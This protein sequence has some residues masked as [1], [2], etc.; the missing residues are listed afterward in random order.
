MINEL[1]NSIQ[2]IYNRKILLERYLMT[3]GGK[4]IINLEKL[5]PLL[6]ILIFDYDTEFGINYYDQN[7]IELTKGEDKETSFIVYDYIINIHTH[8]NI[9]KIEL[10]HKYLVP[11]PDDYEDSLHT[12]HNKKDHFVI[13]PEGIWKYKPNDNLINLFR[14]I[15][16]TFPNSELSS[17]SEGS[18]DSPEIKGVSEEDAEKYNSFKE[19]LTSKIE[20]LNNRLLQTNE[21]KMVCK[22]IFYSPN[23]C[24]NIT[25]DSYYQEM[26][27][28]IPSER[29]G[30]D[31]VLIPWEK[32]WLFEYPKNGREDEILNQMGNRNKLININISKE[33]LKMKIDRTG[34]TYIVF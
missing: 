11:S 16:K 2:A 26:A 14:N 25:L 22:N 21:L 5:K 30:F 24:D 27:N 1:L 3:G 34:A 6:N 33:E 19:P 12:Y 8:P 7:N 31:A 4:I 15:V 29:A 18:S 13:T 17:F 32:Q 9:H 23:D 10:N 20:K 28:L